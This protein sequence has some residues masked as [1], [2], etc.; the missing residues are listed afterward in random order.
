MESELTPPAAPLVLVVDDNEDNLKLLAKLLEVEGYRTAVAESAADARVQIDRQRPDI[1]LLDVVMP[2]VTGLT[3]L[4][5]LRGAESTR[6]LPVILVSA[7]SDT[8]HIVHGLMKGAND[9]MSK[10]VN[11]PELLARIETQLRLSREVRELKDQR[12]SLGMLAMTD[13]LT[14][15]LNRR[16]V[17]EA[18]QIEI[19][20]CSRYGHDLALLMIDLDRF[21]TVND[22]FGHAAGDEV[23]REFTRRATSVLRGSDVLGR[24]GGDEFMCILPETDAV[25]ALQ[26]AERIRR[27]MVSKPVEFE[28]E[29]IEIG[30]SVG[31]ATFDPE[32]PQSWHGLF[33]QADRAL[34]EA[35]S[36]GRNRSH[37]FRHPSESG[38]RQFA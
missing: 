19:D 29:K 2:E 14:G 6:T 37:L 24:C 3:F 16:A 31:L 15:A 4:E 32:V 1:I 23:L 28:S 8:E 34:Y 18:L 7:L 11:L 17:T 20:R 10:P 5:E 33:D 26:A 9:Y 27:A 36:T 13:S 12:D 21:K 38:E 35:K 25:S 22:T 30:I